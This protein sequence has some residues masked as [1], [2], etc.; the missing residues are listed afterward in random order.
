MFRVCEYV[1]PTLTGEIFCLFVE[2]SC[3]VSFV[4]FKAICSWKSNIIFVKPM[5]ISFAY[6]N[7]YKCT[8]FLWN[9][10]KT[11]L[12]GGFIKSRNIDN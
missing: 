11:G 9:L 2:V 12:F 4:I 1:N 6:P 8:C 7:S 10:I 3:W 5:P